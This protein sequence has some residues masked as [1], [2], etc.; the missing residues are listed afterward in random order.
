[1][2]DETEKAVLKQLLRGPAPAKELASTNLRL[3]RIIDVTS[4]WAF[5]THYGLEVC[6]ELGFIERNKTFGSRNEAGVL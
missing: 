5:L 3:R 6:L 1:M 2:N 4:G